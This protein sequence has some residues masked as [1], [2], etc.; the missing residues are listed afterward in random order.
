M[1]RSFLSA[2]ILLTPAPILGFIAVCDAR[3]RRIRNRDVAAAG[4][5]AAAAIL[6]SGVVDH[7]VFV[8]AAAAGAAVA[9]APLAVAWIARPANL[10]GGDVKLTAVLGGLVGLIHPG[11]ALA[12][13]ATALVA[14]LL[15]IRISGTVSAPLAPALV[16][17]ATG[18]LVAHAA[19][20]W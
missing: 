2:L 15:T 1:S 7:Q 18:A 3:V 12:M 9:V 10:G 17:A 4:T 14:T 6:M 13:V 19:M 8:G 11:I 16:I 5:V 20:A